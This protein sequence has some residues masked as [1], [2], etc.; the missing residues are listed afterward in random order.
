MAGEMTKFT[1]G[2]LIA[3]KKV[4]GTDVYSLQGEKLGTI[5]DI[6]IDKLSGTAI[7]A[8]M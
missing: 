4:L 3:A 8:I 1:S 7:C 6:M 5:E 2:R